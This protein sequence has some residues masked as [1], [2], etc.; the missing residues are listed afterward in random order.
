MKG[1]ASFKRRMSLRVCTREMRPRRGEYHLVPPGCTVIRMIASLG[2]LPSR[3]TTR[4]SMLP[5]CCD[6]TGITPTR[7]TILSLLGAFPWVDSPVLATSSSVRAVFDFPFLT[8]A[9]VFVVVFIASVLSFAG[10]SFLRL[11]VL[12]ESNSVKVLLSFV[13]G[14]DDV[15]IT[16]SQEMA[17]NVFRT[18]Y[19]DLTV[20]AS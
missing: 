13:V 8:M 1:T 6:F 17:F 5:I 4:T 2:E 10:Y 7:F 20:E 18:S 14:P 19:G 9:G 16:L 3:A 12:A 15:I 11:R